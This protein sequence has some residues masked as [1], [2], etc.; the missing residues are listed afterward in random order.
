MLILKLTVVPLALLAFGIVERL[1]GPRIAGWLAGFPI[2]AGPLLVFVTLDQGAAF[3]SAAALGAFFGLVPWLAFAMTYAWAARRWRWFWCALIGF[4]VWTLVAMLAVWV[5]DGPRW[6]ETIPL[7][8]FVIALFAQPRGEASDEEREHVWWGLPARMVAGAALTMVITQCASAMGTH[9]SGIFATFPVMGSII[10]I[11]SHVQYG[12]HAVQEAVA[13]M[14]MGLASVG[15]F[16]F[17]AY[18][19][20]AMTGIWTAF[21]LALAASS[22]A[23]ALTWLLFKRKPGPEP[24]T[25]IS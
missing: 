15:A 3:G 18:I 10:A 14:S 7:I 4:A 8:A 21:A 22:T 16:C 6:L 25:T 24:E 2:V 13:G 19:L 23:H 9:W 17:A 5:E 1:H 12:R 11:S 20:L